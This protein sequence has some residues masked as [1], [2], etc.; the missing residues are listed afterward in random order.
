MAADEVN[1]NGV[2]EVHRS[3][4]A[5]MAVRVKRSAHE[6]GKEEE[7]EEEGAEDVSVLVVAVAVMAA[8]VENAK[9]G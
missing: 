2:E 6:K 7:E 8:A 1:E 3:Y 5:E 9:G 4:E